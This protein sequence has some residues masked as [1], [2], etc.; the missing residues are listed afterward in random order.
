MALPIK[1][2]FIFACAMAETDVLR[3]D[4]TIS[5]GI[6]ASIT[7]LFPLPSIQFM[8]AAFLSVHML[9]LSATSDRSGKT[10]RRDSITAR[11]PL[12]IMFIP[13]AS[14][15]KQRRRMYTFFP[16]TVVFA[17]SNFPKLVV[18]SNTS[19]SWRKLS[20][21]PIQRAT[22]AASVAEGI[23]THGARVMPSLRM[24]LDAPL[25]WEMALHPRLVLAT[26]HPSVVAMGMYTDS[27]FRVMG[28]AIP[29][30]MGMYPTTISQ[31][32]PRT[33]L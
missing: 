17:S 9:P 24:V 26:R 10:C 21:V 5:C 28:P 14:P 18:D 11:L 1:F 3:V 20:G 16:A 30:G 6:V 22:S 25:P 8:A 31:F 12:L 15:E 19:F 23:R 29:T 27:P 33:R 13:M 32:A 4:R 2:L 7:T